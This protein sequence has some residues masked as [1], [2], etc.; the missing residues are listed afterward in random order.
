MNLLQQAQAAFPGLTW[1]ADGTPEH[2]ARAHVAGE[3]S[4]GI[5]RRDDEFHA[6]VLYG[7]AG[8]DV[9]ECATFNDAAKYLRDKLTALRDG[10]NVALGDDEAL[11][12]RARLR[13]IAA[14]V[15]KLPASECAVNCS[16]R[17]HLLTNPPQLQLCNC[18]AKAIAALKELCREPT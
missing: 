8:G 17:V 6:C 15:G 1:V 16:S 11:R 18:G 5:E 4:V 13:D 9:E 7:T 3:L 12:L 2:Y 14:A 10:L